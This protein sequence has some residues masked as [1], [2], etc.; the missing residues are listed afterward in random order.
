[1]MLFTLLLLPVLIGLVGLI[2]GKGKVTWKEFLVHEAIIVALISAGYFV[3]LKSSLTDT[4]IWNSSIARK[5]QETSGCCHS[6][7]CNCRQEC[8]GSGENQSC[9]T[10]CDTCYQ[11]LHDIEWLAMTTTQEIVYTDGCNPPG[12]SA[13]NRWQKIIVGEPAATEHSYTNY[14]KGNPDSILRRQGALKKFKAKIPDYPSVYDYY[15]ANR[16]I[17]VGAPIGNIADLNKKLSEINARLGA[18]KQVNIVV[19][20]VNEADQMYFEALREA[21]LGGKKNDFIVIV[22]TPEFPKISWAAV[23]SWTKNEEVKIEV[24]DRV[25]GLA[26]FDGEKILGIIAEEVEKKFVR[27]PMADFEYL[28][29]TLEPPAW[30]TWLIFIIG[31]LL[32]IGLQIYFWNEDPFHD[33]ERRRYFGYGQ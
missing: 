12:S 30:A 26:E 6:Y 14:I 31:C 23:L 32:S 28:K 27:R 29:S 20:I 22:G 21:W 18:P 33:N 4:E 17:A 10:V 8:S 16:F 7:P 11:H 1:M 9:S 2:A 15:R 13:P 24:R 3:A 25:I 19:V 5:W